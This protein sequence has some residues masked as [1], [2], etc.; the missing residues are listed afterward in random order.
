MVTGSEAVKVKELS[1][2]EEKEVERVSRAEAPASP[3][4]LPHPSSNLFA[5]ACASEGE[6]WAEAPASPHMSSDWSWTKLW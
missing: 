4:D 2:K 1:E 3:P 6:L 5:S